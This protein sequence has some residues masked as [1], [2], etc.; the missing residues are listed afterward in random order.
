M[1]SELRLLYEAFVLFYKKVE[2]LSPLLLKSGGAIAP[3]AP[4]IAK[5]M[6]INFCFPIIWHMDIRPR[7]NN[8]DSQWISISQSI[9]YY[10]A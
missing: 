3:L 5:P 8:R 2:R 10:R 7:L 9:T 6:H 4:P 1:Y